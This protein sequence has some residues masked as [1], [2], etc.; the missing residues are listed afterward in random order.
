VWAHYSTIAFFT[1]LDLNRNDFPG[2]IVLCIIVGILLNHPVLQLAGWI[3]GATAVFVG[4][5][6]FFLGGGDIED[7]L[8]VPLSIIIGC[9]LVSAGY[10]LTKYR[11]YILFYLRRLWRAMDAVRGNTGRRTSGRIVQESRDDM[12]RGLLE[13]D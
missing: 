10:T 4:I 6:S 1:F 11:A 13:R 2:M 7:L 8:E 9:G 12:T 3:G 5:F